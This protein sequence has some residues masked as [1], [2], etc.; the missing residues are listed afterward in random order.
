M[1]LVFVLTLRC[2]TFLMIGECV[3]LFCSVVFFHTKPKDWQRNDSFRVE[4]DVKPQLN[5]SI[6]QTC[7]SWACSATTRP[8]D[9]LALVS[10]S[11]SCTAAS[12]SARCS[13]HRSSPSWYS[14]CR[15]ASSDAR[16]CSSVTWRESSKS[17][18]R[19]RSVDTSVSAASHA[20]SASVN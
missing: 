20:V 18:I 13:R 16:R 19:W 15:A 3:L 4:W 11:V 9:A 2:S 7:A 12:S 1:A 17:V 5:Q 14:V 6:N 8:S 10:V